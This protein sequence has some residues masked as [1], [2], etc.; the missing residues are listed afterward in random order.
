MFRPKRKTIIFY[1][2]S[3]LIILLAAFSLPLIRSPFLSLFRNPLI[4]VKLIGR[5][6]N[7]LIF[8]HR[9]YIQKDRLN[10]EVEFLRSKLN[11]LDE[12]YQE[13][14]RLNNLL[15]LKKD[16]SYRMIASRVI[17]RSS[18]NWSSV[19]IIDKGKLSGIRRGMPVITYLGLAGRIIECNRSTSKVMLLNDPA[20]SVSALIQRSRQEGLVCGTLGRQLVMKYLAEEADIMIGD[21]I[22]SS[23]LT[24]AYPK[25]FLIGTVVG[26]NRGFSGLSKV[27]IIEPAVNPYGIEE[28]LIIVS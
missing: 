9:N 7:G 4:I 5:E 26:I 8:Y 21:K 20:F 17:G 1:A 23:G 3:V 16:S 28:V 11:M 27:A 15:S 14:M 25:G 12:L 6:V 22:I 2:V 13:N 19:L 18:T 24:G 10:K